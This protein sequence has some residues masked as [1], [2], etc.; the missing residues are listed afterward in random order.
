MGMRQLGQNV[1][2]V[3]DRV[4]KGESLIV[5]EH[6]NPVAHLVPYSQAH[7]L[8]DMIARGEA[9]SAS[10]SLSAF[11]DTCEPLTSDITG[12]EVLARMREDER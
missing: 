4:K 5:T 8:E 11:F 7:P 2:R 12:S 6:G 10:S 1:S 9:I 3:L